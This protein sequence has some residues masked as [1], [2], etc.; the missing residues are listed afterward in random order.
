MLC[1]ELFHVQRRDWVWLVAEEIVRAAL[2][3]IPAVLWLISRVRLA[4]EEVVDELTVLAT[5]QRRAYM[6]ALLVFAEIRRQA[7][8]PAFARR[9]HLFRRMVLISKEAVM[10]SRRIA[11]SCPVMA[12]VLVPAAVHVGAFP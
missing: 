3:F 12:L 1:H 11:L 7:P 5:S 4:R 10:S 9:R 2:G 8:A 6:E